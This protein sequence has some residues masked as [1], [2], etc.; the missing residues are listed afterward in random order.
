MP[1]GRA[2]VALH[3]LRMTPCA[4]L[5]V[6]DSTTLGDSFERGDARSNPTF[7]PSDSSSLLQPSSQNTVQV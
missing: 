1:M 7:E 2:A 5:Q 4:D 6:Q 3:P